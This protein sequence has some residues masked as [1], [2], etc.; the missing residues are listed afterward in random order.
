MCTTV[1]TGKLFQFSLKR[2]EKKKKK[3]CKEVVCKSLV[4]SNLSQPAAQRSLCFTLSA[5]FK[6]LCACAF[7]T[8]QYFVKRGGGKFIPLQS[9][10]M[11]VKAWTGAGVSWCKTI[12]CAGSAFCEVLPQTPLSLLPP[13][14]YVRTGYGAALTWSHV[15]QIPLSLAQTA[16]GRN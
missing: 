7:F 9:E 16:L 8:V 15:S 4:Q 14:V 10:S 11:A 1:S 2:R 12:T 5:A 3:A 13:L 6:R